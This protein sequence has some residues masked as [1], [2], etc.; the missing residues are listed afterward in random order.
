MA[1]PLTLT[2]IGFKSPHNPYNLS[3]EAM[4]AL[5][6]SYIYKTPDRPRVLLPSYSPHYAL[7][8]ALR[9]KRIIEDSGYLY[10]SGCSHMCDTTV[11]KLTPLGIQEYERLLSMYM[12]EDAL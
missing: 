8:S 6:G 2:Y 5:V 9:K 4:G 10:D 1:P 12:E 3:T 11:W 7:V